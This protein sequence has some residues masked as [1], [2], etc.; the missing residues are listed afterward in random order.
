VE[1]RVRIC[2]PLSSD[3]AAFNSFSAT[4]A[5]KLKQLATLT[6]LYAVTTR[7]IKSDETQPNKS[8]LYPY[9]TYTTY[10]TYTMYMNMYLHMNSVVYT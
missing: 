7:K 10:T 6:S 4:F 2:E 8:F 3:S 9:T 5:A 1:G